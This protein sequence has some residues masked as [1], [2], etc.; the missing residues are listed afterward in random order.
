MTVHNA[1]RASVLTS[2]EVEALVQEL[3]TMTL[4]A[5]RALWV[6]RYGG[7]EPKVRSPELLS[8]MLAWR[9]QV[10]AAGGLDPALVEALSPKPPRIR[11]AELPLGALAT[12]EWK[13]ERHTV[14]ARGEGLVY[15]GEVYASLSAVARQITGTRWNGP[16]FFG[17]RQAGEP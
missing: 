14:E 17:L 1:W 9:I 2:A 10:E 6:T 11:T 3:P 5:L 12:R 15:R 8:R 4:N 16:R 13:G 7:D